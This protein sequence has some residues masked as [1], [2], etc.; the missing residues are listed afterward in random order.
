M[1]DIQDIS[2]ID[3]AWQKEASLRR[4]GLRQWPD[5]NIMAAL[6]PHG[7]DWECVYP[8]GA[9]TRSIVWNGTEVAIINPQ[10][11]LL[12]SVEGDIAM[13]MRACPIMDKALRVIFSLAG[14]PANLDLIKRVARAGYGAAELS[15]PPLLDPHP[16]DE[17]EDE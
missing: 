11:A 16:E 5:R 1:A 6:V 8:R 7:G 13:G 15:P 17:E 10:G 12:D 2:A 4:L 14:D 3:N 9:A